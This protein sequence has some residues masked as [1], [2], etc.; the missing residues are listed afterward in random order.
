MLLQMYFQSNSKGVPTTFQVSRKFE[1]GCKE[2]LRVLQESLTGISKM[3]QGYFEKRM[4]EGVSRKFKGFKYK[5][6]FKQ[7]SGMFKGRFK[8]VSRT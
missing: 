6:S 7:V 8:N 1:R 2:L 3:F 4:F 5:A